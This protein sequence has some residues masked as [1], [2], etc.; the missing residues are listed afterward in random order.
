MMYRSV[1]VAVLLLTGCTTTLWSPNYQEVWINGFYV[2]V[3]TNELFVTTRDDAFLFP[4]DEKFSKALM[5][6]REAAF[7]PRF[8]DF[9]IT[10]DNEVTGRVSLVFIEPDASD[11]FIK[12]LRFLGFISDPSIS[13]MYLSMS[14]R[15]KGERYTVEG[16]VPLEKLEDEYRVTVERPD[17]FSETAGKI[18]ATPATIT[19]DAVVT[20]PLTFIV[21]TI[22]AV[23]SP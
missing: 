9:K 17:T 6:T 20:V 3:E 4:I 13:D 10:K 19:I 16:E 15:I 14:E 11:S 18:I 21:A 7:Y 22:M 2:N 8:Q 1:I 23:G 5:L 12:E